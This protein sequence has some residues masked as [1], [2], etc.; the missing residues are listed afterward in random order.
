MKT[1]SDQRKIIIDA[2]HDRRTAVEM[3]INPAGVERD[4]TVRVKLS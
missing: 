1:A 3:A 2:Y 4:L